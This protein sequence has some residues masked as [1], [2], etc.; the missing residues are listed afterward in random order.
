M[1]KRLYWQDDH[2][3]S[4]SAQVVAIVGHE[5]ACDQTSFYPGG[6]GQPPDL[7]SIVSGDDIW[8]VVSVHADAEGVVWHTLDGLAPPDLLNREVRLEVD[9]PDALLWRATTRCCTF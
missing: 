2:C 6:G 8:P 7:G 4:A 3:Y 5:L 1:T 9:P